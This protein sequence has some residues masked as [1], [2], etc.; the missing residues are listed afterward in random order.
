[1]SNIIAL[2]SCLESKEGPWLHPQGHEVGVRVYPDLRAGELVIIDVESEHG[3][4][5]IPVRGGYTPLSGLAKAKRYRA[6]KSG[7]GTPT[8]VEVVRNGKTQRESG[9]AVDPKRAIE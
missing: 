5:S 3:S 9:D 8:T 1:M 7:H 2:L 4:V 6:V